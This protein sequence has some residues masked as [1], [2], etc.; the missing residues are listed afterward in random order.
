M[1][2]VNFDVL[3][4][5]LNWFIVILMLVIA[6]FVVD[7]LATHIGPKRISVPGATDA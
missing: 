2:I 6:G 4:H 7:I 1:Q 3:K 5:P